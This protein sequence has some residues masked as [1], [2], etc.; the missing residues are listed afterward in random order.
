MPD[1]TAKPTLPTTLKE[2]EEH[3]D[4]VTRR[5]PRV[6]PR[7][8]ITLPDPGLALFKALPDPAFTSI[9]VTVEVDGQ[10][11]AGVVTSIAFD[12]VGDATTLTPTVTEPPPARTL[13]RGRGVGF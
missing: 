7:I 5:D 10:P 12:T 13:P 2:W 1:D 3:F 6:P 9:P 8:R 11:R 4:R